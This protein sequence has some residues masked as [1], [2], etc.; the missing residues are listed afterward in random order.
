MDA[1]PPRLPSTTPRP[2][3]QRQRALHTDTLRVSD[4]A[5]GTK[6]YQLRLPQSQSDSSAPA[7]SRYTGSTEPSPI[8]R[9][10]AP[11]CPPA[12]ICSAP[13]DCRYPV[14]L[15]LTAPVDRLVD[16]PWALVVAA[17]AAP[18]A[19]SQARLPHGSGAHLSPGPCGGSPA[20]E[21]GLRPAKVALVPGRAFGRRWLRSTCG[22]YFNSVLPLPPGN[23]SRSTALPCAPRSQ[24]LRERQDAIPRCLAAF[25]ARDPGRLASTLTLQRARRS[26]ATTSSNYKTA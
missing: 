7:A 9:P 17:Y 8:L 18:R 14:T 13:H 21:P 23:G 5:A 26:I 3:D 16:F 20:A 10:V 11:S 12:S 19:A 4:I 25:P 22:S 6:L 24:S 15:S 2:T 1:R